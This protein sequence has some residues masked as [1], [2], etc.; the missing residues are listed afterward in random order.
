QPGRQLLLLKLGEALIGPT[1]CEDIWQPGPPATDLTLAGA[2]VIANISASPFHVGKG[3]E[4]EEMLVTRAGDNACWVV[5]V[6]AV[7]GQD[8]LIF[9]GH[10][11]VIDEEGEIVARAPALAEALLVVDI[12]ATTAVARPLVDARRRAPAGRPRG[13]RAGGGGTS[14]TRQS[15][16]PGSPAPLRSR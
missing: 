1:V 13:G 14:P 10:S 16:P 3:Q 15:S 12:D 2:H 9:D 6:N 4:A 8:E 11:L 7:G 5:L